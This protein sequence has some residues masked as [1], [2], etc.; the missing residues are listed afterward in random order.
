MLEQW[1]DISTNE[2]GKT[3]TKLVPSNDEL[4]K[5]AAK[6]ERDAG[7]GVPAVVFCGAGAGGV[8]LGDER[9][10]GA[11]VWRAGDSADDVGGVAGA[12]CEGDAYGERAGAAVPEYA[13]AA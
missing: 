6:M 1:V 4:Q 12:D 8:P 11:G 5:E 10:A 2:A 3:V 7:S 9:S 13:A